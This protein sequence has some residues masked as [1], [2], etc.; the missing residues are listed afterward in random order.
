MVPLPCPP[1]ARFPQCCQSP[2]Q[3]LHG[4]PEA[5]C[6]FSIH[7]HAA[8]SSTPFILSSCFHVLSAKKVLL[9]KPWQLDPFFLS[10]P[11]VECPSDL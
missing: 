6:V 11:V 1:V 3:A 9:L 5:N 7:H 10:T 2:V 8:Q 4:L